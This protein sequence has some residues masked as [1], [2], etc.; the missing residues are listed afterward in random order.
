MVENSPTKTAIVPLAGVIGWPVEHSLS[1]RVHGF[2]LERYNIAG[3]YEKRAVKP[4]GLSPELRNLKSKGFRGVNL[5]LPHKEAALAALD[6]VD[7]SARRI[8]AVNTVIVRDD[9]KLEGRNTDIFGFSENLRA[10]GFKPQGAAVVLGAGGAARAAVAALLEMGIRDIRVMN[11]TRERA[12]KLAG[13][14]GL[15]VAL[16]NWG[17]HTALGD[18]ALLVNATS[19]GLKGQPPL[20]IDIGALAKDAWVTDMVYAPLE[21]DLLK[22]ARSRN[23]KTVDGLGMLL[24]QARP[25]FKAFFGRDPEV[26]GD[27]R[28]YVLEGVK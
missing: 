23:H 16:Y 2:W 15:S 1:P 24:H 11:R 12:E 28:S 8:G 25:A 17:D 26:T 18:A 13:D 10:A 27:L 7:P 3:A 9:G 20:E 21:T 22:R 19:L 14:F 5:T 6:I 4:E